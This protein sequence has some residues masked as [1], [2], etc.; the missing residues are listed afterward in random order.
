MPW[1]KFFDEKKKRWDGA[2]RF[3]LKSNSFWFPE[4]V[5]TPDTLTFDV[6][7]AACQEGPYYREEDEDVKP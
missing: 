7:E 4:W 5:A 3:N 6:S 2:L 1:F